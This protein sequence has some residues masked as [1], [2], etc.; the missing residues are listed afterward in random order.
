VWELTALDE[1]GQDYY[2]R[3]AFDAALRLIG[4]AQKGLDLNVALLTVGK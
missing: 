3:N 2:D 1:R 4:H